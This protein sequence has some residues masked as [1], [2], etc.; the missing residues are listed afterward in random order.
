[1]MNGGTEV[2][3]MD[4]RGWLARAVPGPMQRGTLGGLVFLLT[5][6]PVLVVRAAVIEPYRIPSG[7]MQPTVLIGDHVLA[8]KFRYS[9]QLPLVGTVARWDTPRVGDVVV[10]RYP[11]DRSLTYVKRVVGVAGDQV[12]VRRN[13]PILNGVPVGWEPIA[14][15]SNP[16]DD[17]CREVASRGFVETVPGPLGPRSYPVLVNRGLPGALVNYLPRVVPD[18]MVFLLGDNR[19]QAEDS[20][21]WGFVPVDDIRGHVQQV[22]FSEDLCAGSARFGRMLLDINP[23]SQ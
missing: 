13:Q 17:Q 1:M 8:V 11:R 22:W 7:S 19:D 23:V 20:R 9:F 4:D 3:R 5:F 6:V 12:E 14:E 16:L 18:G 10:F 2:V 15:L 21:R